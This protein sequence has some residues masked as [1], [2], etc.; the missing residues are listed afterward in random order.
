MYT[1]VSINRLRLYR[2]TLHENDLQADTKFPS[3]LHDSNNAVN[4]IQI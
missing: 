2:C 1:V 3:R 4:W